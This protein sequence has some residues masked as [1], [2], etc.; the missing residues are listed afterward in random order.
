MR[1]GQIFLLALF[2]ALASAAAW[3]FY[4]DQSNA[5]IARGRGNMQVTVITAP[6]ETRTFTDIVEALGT[7]KARESVTLTSRVSDTVREVLFEDGQSVK[8][9]DVL[10]RLQD[11][12]EKAQLSEA[13]ANLNEAERQFE[14]VK[15]L[16][17]QGNAST[18]ALDTQQRNMDEA[19][20]RLDAAQA[21]L[22]DQKI[23]APFDGLLGLRQV[24][25]G[26]LITPS[27]AITTIDDI[28]IIKMDFSVPERFIA[29]LAPGQR[30]YARVEAYPGR[31]FE[32]VITTIDSRI[33]PATRSVV[34]RAEVP[35]PDHALKPG[36]LMIVKAVSREWE[37]VSIPEESVV[38]SNGDPFVYVVKE[39]VARRTSVKLGLRRPGYVEVTDGIAAD[40]SVVIEGTWRLGGSEV[41]VRVLS[42]ASAAAVGKLS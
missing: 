28:D 7:A 10:V 13:K 23:V 20:F 6:A 4:G 3:L 33:D 30:V 1:I 12:E 18:A 19:R 41:P 29:T 26:S 9:G 35:N 17:K 21:R 25:A 11:N 2:I 34:I 8:Q 32:G 5:G 22:A 27:T 37:G 39:G 36:L 15:N 40:E 14:R 38:M 31:R 24:S 16:V 42:E